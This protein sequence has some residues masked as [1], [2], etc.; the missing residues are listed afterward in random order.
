MFYLAL[1]VHDIQMVGTV[2][3]HSHG[4]CPGL[5]IFVGYVD[6][7]LI[8]LDDNTGYFDCIFQLVFVPRLR[9]LFGSILQLLAELAHLSSVTLFRYGN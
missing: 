5:T 4:V 6:P 7:Q 9:T 2:K 8:G 3:V 1:E